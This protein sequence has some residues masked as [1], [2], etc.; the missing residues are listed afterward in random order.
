MKTLK[1]TL[2]DLYDEFPRT[3]SHV[4]CSEATYE[5][6]WKGAVL[7]TSETLRF[8]LVD[9]QVCV[10]AAITRND[11]LCLYDRH[12]QFVRTVEFEEPK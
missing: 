9:L 12:H 8:S 6:I 10:D 4:R 11:V 5:A 3:F 7:R 2:K 1:E